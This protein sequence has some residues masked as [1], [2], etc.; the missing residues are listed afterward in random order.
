M[1]LFCLTELYWGMEFF[2]TYRVGPQTFQAALEQFGTQGVVELITLMGFY[3]ML[4][5]NA[6]AVDLGLPGHHSEP[7]LPV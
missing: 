7:A 4:A 3:A 1:P 6:N 5:F 2:K